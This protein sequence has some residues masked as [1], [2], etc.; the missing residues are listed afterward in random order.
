[1]SRSGA[2]AGSAHDAVSRSGAA[3][4][5][6][7]DAVSRSG[8]AAG[9]AHDAVS[10]SGA[11][12]GSAHDAVSR[13]GAAAGSAHDAVSRSG[14][15]AGSAHADVSAVL[16]DPRPGPGKDA[17]LVQRMF[18]R[19]APR[20]DL[21]N[22]LFSLGRDRHWRRAAVVAAQPQPD[23]VIVD[24]AAGTGALAR[25]LARAAARAGGPATVI[26]ADLSWNMLAT[27]ASRTAAE[28]LQWCN[29]DA[30]RLPLGDGRADAVTIAFGLRNLPDI[31]AGLSEF[32]RV[33]RPG[34]RLVVL[35]FSRP[36]W[37]PF[38]SLYLRYLI[39]AMPHVA[40]IF[41]SD[42]AAYRYL[43]ESIQAWPTQQALG[44]II[45]GAGWQRVQWRNLTGGIVAVHRAVR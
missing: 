41:T 13:S 45:A 20:Y 33:V 30:M 36:T 42:P 24:V 1:V 18:D 25:G 12:A 37:A 35:E 15:A 27:G 3:A 29:A 31:A 6:A 32:A 26:G 14:A 38:R 22:T 34:G 7:H 28:P 43:A 8:A 5:S 16:P 10:R 2:A 39:G 19:V 11:A 23:E 9:S 4:G 40:R 21:A 17:E 44:R